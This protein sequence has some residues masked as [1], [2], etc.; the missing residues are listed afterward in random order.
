LAAAAPEE[1]GNLNAPKGR[2]SRPKSFFSTEEES[3][4]VDAVGKAERRTS[5]EI[6]I[7]L[8]HRCKGGDAYARAKTVFEELGMTATSERN[9]V[10]IYM[11]TGDQLFSVIGDAGI[12]TKVGEDFWGDV[13]ATMSANFT[14]GSF[15]AGMTLGIAQVGE[16]LAAFFPYAGDEHDVNELSDEISHGDG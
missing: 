7:H 4:I 6:R 2:S 5:G 13:V 11:A 14:Q 16:K 1:D 3:A 9:G 15:A 10:L 8:E 12:D